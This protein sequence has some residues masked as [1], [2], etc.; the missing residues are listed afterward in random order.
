LESVYESV[1]ARDLVR[2]GLVV[3]RQKAVAFDY[4]GMPPREPTMNE[5]ETRAEN[6]DPA[7]EAGRLGS[8]RR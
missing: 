8:G 5:A 7:V 1:L 6:I 2:R 3:E 4:D